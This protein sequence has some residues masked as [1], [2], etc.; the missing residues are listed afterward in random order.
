MTSAAVVLSVLL[1]VLVVRPWRREPARRRPALP[2]GAGLHRTVA[3]DVGSARHVVV[4][5]ALAVGLVVGGPVVALAAAAA[6]ALAG[7]ATDRLLARR[8]QV[9][10]A[11]AVPDLV[12]LFL[13][14]ASAGQPV[15]GALAV[16]A[17]RAPSAV[18]PAVSA[19]RERFQRGLP[20]AECLAE[21]GS[22]LGPDGVPLTDALRQA[23]SAGVPLVPL[24]EGVAAT[25][26]DR[27]RRRAQEVARR[28]PVTML[29]PMVACILPAAILLAV[30][31]VL[32]VS[33]RS[34]SP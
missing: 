34:L 1:V 12:D 14:S 13:V 7:P 26:R 23:A 5:L 31:P 10:V 19:A 24:L 28:L 4:A 33:V 17:P 21:L 8:H 32:L 30:V 9:A 20:L 18:L 27:R 6:A 25:A 16:V 29:F 22:D 3:V 15:A 2:E 11:T